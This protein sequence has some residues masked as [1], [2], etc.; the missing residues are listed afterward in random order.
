MGWPAYSP[1]VSAAS[2]VRHRRQHADRTLPAS[3]AFISRALIRIAGYLLLRTAQSSAVTGRRVRDPARRQTSRPL[4]FAS[5]PRRAA[6][7]P[8]DE[9]S[10]RRVHVNGEAQGGDQVV[11]G[12][13]PE[14]AVLV[15]GVLVHPDLVVLEF[16]G[17]DLGF[18]CLWQVEPAALK[19][20]LEPRYH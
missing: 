8:G 6:G 19:P 15:V 12:A 17:E 20:G 13:D 5:Q 4:A 14:G 3:G 11:V 7:G 2:G 10:R 1:P 9:P 18:S 16:L